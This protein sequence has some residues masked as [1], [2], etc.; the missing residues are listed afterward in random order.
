M[1]KVIDLNQYKEDNTECI[2]GTAMCVQC[3]HQWEAVQPVDGE[4]WL[5]CPSCKLMRG[6]FYYHVSAPG[7]EVY[8]CQC[9]NQL[10]IVTPTGTWCPNCATYLIMD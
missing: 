9:G 5:E 4:K 7:G 1:G 10:F 6:H 8:E 3:R 2:T